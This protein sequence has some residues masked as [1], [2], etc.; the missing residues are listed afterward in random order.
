METPNS[1]RGRGHDGARARS[2][3]LYGDQSPESQALDAGPI[4]DAESEML[5]MEKVFQDKRKNSD[6]SSDG[7]DFNG[8]WD[9]GSSSNGL[10]FNGNGSNGSKGEN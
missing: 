8:D 6:S 7:H 1:F 2:Q 4:R 5:P 10:E 9:A 3:P